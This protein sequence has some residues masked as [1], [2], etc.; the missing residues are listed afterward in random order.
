[1]TIQERARAELRYGDELLPAYRAALEACLPA[2]EVARI[3]A[4]RGNPA[5]DRLFKPATQPIWRDRLLGRKPATVP[6]PDPSLTGND[7]LFGGRFQETKVDAFALAAKRIMARQVDPIREQ[8]P[9]E[10]PPELQSSRF[11]EQTR[12]PEND[13]LFGEGPKPA[14]IKPATGID[15]SLDYLFQK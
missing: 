4:A 11:Q 14:A 1:M 5:H 13:W 2:D 10:D 6:T 8:P 3:R 12:N 7:R 9:I 15:H